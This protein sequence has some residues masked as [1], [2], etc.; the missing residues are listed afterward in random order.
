MPTGV[1][2]Y[3]HRV[4]PVVLVTTDSQALPDLQRVLAPDVHPVLDQSVTNLAVVG[5]GGLAAE[6]PRPA[7]G[8]AQGQLQVT[9]HRVISF[10]SIRVTVPDTLSAAG[11]PT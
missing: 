2:G 1:V 8:A 11:N 3:R 4:R 7:S 6:L 10:L 5:A 9:D